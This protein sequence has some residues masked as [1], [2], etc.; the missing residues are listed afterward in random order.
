M[1]QGDRPV[2]AIG[3]F[4]GAHRG[5]RA[6]ADA[7]RALANR[8]GAHAT[9]ALTFEPHPRRYFRPETPLFRLTP[10]AEKP[11]RLMALG[12]DRVEIVPFDARLAGMSAEAFIAEI[13]V[14]RLNAIGV[15]V[16]ADFHFGK[17]RTG[18]PDL[19]T[20]CGASAGFAVEL[21]RPF[22]DEQG[23]IVS[24]SAIRAA[25][26]NG[27][28][29]LANGM[30]G[31]SYSVAGPVIHGEKRGRE[32]GYPTANLRLDPD[33]GLAH[34]IYAVRI[35]LEDRHLAGVASFGRRPHF[36]NGAPL[37]EVHVFDFAGDLYGRMIEVSFEAWL[38]PEAR[39][40]SLEAL[41]R[42]MDADSQAAR[43]LLAANA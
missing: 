35:A 13:L 14:G 1:M 9:L 11:R 6:V 32:L 26:A 36:D 22:C 5:H 23:R 28:L 19:L 16:G 21:V 12:F 20:A 8:L 7:A 31:R 18:T 39:F 3:N 25:L 42:Q 37:L 34:G 27:D 38:R 43:A 15:V 10:A 30:L 24:S 33:C 4:D 2:V 29:A 41:L 17:G 40:E